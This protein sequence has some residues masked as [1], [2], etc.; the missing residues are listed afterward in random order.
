MVPLPGREKNARPRKSARLFI[1]AR[2]ERR[3][4]SWAIDGQASG[5]EARPLLAP[6][7]P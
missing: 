6:L 7:G 1:P 3:L 4:L 5:M 2:E